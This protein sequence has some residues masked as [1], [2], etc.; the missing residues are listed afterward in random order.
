[1]DK[2]IIPPPPFSVSDIKALARR[3]GLR[4]CVHALISLQPLDFLALNPPF[5]PHFFLYLCLK[6]DAAQMRGKSATPPLERLILSENRRDER[7]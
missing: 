7:Q 1:M 6:T 4:L 5:I 3:C 2:V